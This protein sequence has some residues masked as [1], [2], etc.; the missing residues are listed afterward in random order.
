MADTPQKFPASSASKGVLN[1]KKTKDISS[2]GEVHTDYVQE[3][4]NEMDLPATTFGRVEN[5][6]S[7]VNSTR[8]HWQSK[9]VTKFRQRNDKT[10]LMQ[11]Y[12]CKTKKT[13]VT[14]KAGK[15]PTRPTFKLLKSVAEDLDG[16]HERRT[17]EAVDKAFTILHESFREPIIQYKVDVT[18]TIVVNG[19]ELPALV[20]GTDVT[21]KDMDCER[22]LQTARTITIGEP[23]EIWQEL[24]FR[25]PSVLNPAKHF[26]TSSGFSKQARKSWF[27]VSADRRD[28]FT[29]TIAAK[30]KITILLEKPE[31]TDHV[32]PSMFQ[33]IPRNIVHNGVLFNVNEQAVLSN[34]GWLR[35]HTHQADTY[36]GFGVEK[37]RYYASVPTATQYMDA[38]SAKDYVLI[39]ESI[40]PWKYNTWRKEQ[41]YIIP[42]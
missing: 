27:S 23:V 31:P 28:G 38:V 30:V 36:Y 9:D 22:A 41:T 42:E 3:V 40:L 25:F 20:A 2:N 15:G 13:I 14:Q 33:I 6:I 18:R 32:Y 35:A 34:G 11:D 4:Q 7:P 19:T 17:D 5:K 21:L 16:V 10:S 8:A 37:F 29:K 12:I 39:S 26:Q 24:K 1:E